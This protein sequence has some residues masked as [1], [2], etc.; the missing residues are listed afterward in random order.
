MEILHFEDLG[1]T[2]VI[3]ECSLGVIL[4]IDNCFYVASG[5]SPLHKIWKQSDHFLWRY[6]ISKIWG[7]WVSFGCERSCSSA[8]KVS[9]LLMEIMHF[10]DLGD[11]SVVSECSLGVNG[12]HYLAPGG[13]CEV[14]FSPCLSVCVFVCVC[15]CVCVRPIFW[16]FI[17]RQLEEISTWN[18]YKILIVLYSIH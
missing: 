15:V 11:I 7:L 16:Y 18:L 14:L 4:V 6:C 2:S 9:T 8:R 13:G 1:D 17:S 5:T 3:S 10:E 12:S